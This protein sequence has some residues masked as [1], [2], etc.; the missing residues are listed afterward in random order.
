MPQRH[1]YGL[2]RLFVRHPNAANL[3][4]AVMLLAGVFSLWRM[5]TQFFPTVEIPAISISISW[6]GAS[7]EDVE[8]NIVEALEP[9][10]RF[11]SGLD[12]LLAFAREGAATFNMEF[13]SDTD[14]QGA[15]SDVEAAVDGVTTL[16]DES[17][18]P[19]ITQ[20]Q[21]YE[22]VASIALSGPFPEAT[23]KRYAK[24]LRD[25]LLEAGIDRVVF[26]GFRDEEI[27]VQVRPRDLR[28]LDLTVED[29]AARISNV[30]R[31]IPSGILEGSVDRQ[32]R[33][34]GLTETAETVA[35]IEV[36]GLPGG[37]KIV[38]RDIAL[39]EERFERDAPIGY[40]KENRAIKL[41]VQRAASA[42][43]LK[44]AEILDDYLDK[45]LPTLPPTLKVTKFDV[46]A[47]L[48]SQRINLLVKNGLG[49]L[50]LVL[51]V[52]F[53]FLNA[54]IAFWVAVGIPVAMMATM[55]VMF[56]SGQSINMVSL[57]ALILTLGIIV[58][59]AIVVGEHT[60]TLRERGIEPSEAAE[61][62]A[63]RM[64]MPVMAATLTT[65]AAFMPIFM[66][67]KVIG[68]IMEALPLV[69][70]AVLVASVIECFLILPG[71]LQHALMRGSKSEPGRFRT[72]F[73][74]GFARFRDGPFRS[75]AKS[76]FE[77]RYTT[78]AVTIGALII[79][80]GLIVGGRIGF[81]FFPAPEPE[82]IEANV[83]FAAGTP[84]AEADAALARIAR[85]LDAA[86]A[87]LTD[88]KGGLVVTSYTT[89]GRAGE[90]VG[91]SLAVIEAELKPAEERTIRTN[92]VIKA[93]TAAVPDIPGVEQLS[94]AGRRGGPPGRDVHVE[95]R[96]KKPV[97]LKQAALEVRDAL[98]Q[99][100]GVSA[101]SDDLAYGKQ[102][103]ILELTPRGSTLGFTTESVGAQVRNAFEGRIAKRFAR[104]DEEITLRVK[105][106]HSSDGIQ[107]LRELYLRSPGGEE[108]PLTEVISVREK[109]G[110]SVIQRR[111]GKPVVGI[112]GEVDQAVTDNQAIVDAMQAGPVPRIAAK[113]GLDYTFRGRAE[114][115]AETFADLKVGG[116][117]ALLIIYII[118]AWVFGSYGKPLII[119]AIIPFGLVGAI[120]GHLVMGFPLT[121]LSFFGLLGLS[122][123]LVNDSII[124]VNQVQRRI[125][126][127]ESLHD[128]AIGGAQDRLRAVLLTSLTTIGGLT[129]LMFE[130]SLQAQFLLP[131]AITLVFGLAVAT[132][133]VLVL[134]PALLGIADDL[135]RR[136]HELYRLVRP[137]AA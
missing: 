119:M 5:N 106:R 112:Y 99:L 7:A 102:E 36:K 95:L 86:E 82:M 104:G 137:K 32:L 126:E 114:E 92:T 84:L 97:I 27:W 35:G 34:I 18:R 11:I 22:D 132:L 85:A 6:P 116:M 47:N 79:S 59:D 127:G 111:D 121:I 78:V 48:V 133:L 46:R 65:Q 105:E 73:D 25:G 45:V 76:G 39:I 2:I 20:F 19:V 71:H 118:L 129:P 49:G 56:L 87:K 31:D 66:V 101:I 70:I 38:L 40:Q 125:S 15:L 96:G 10:L 136:I 42:D 62:G 120:F 14:M 9:E 51:I 83:V 107:A 98:S 30:S 74:R 29:I 61:R 1:T 55:A 12:K 109:A 135:S 75:L 13:E 43:T 89:R 77:W 103:L 33:A 16:P 90:S 24:L 124:L 67:R 123:I 110:F 108:V 117:L 69:V 88:G 17:E 54:R 93:W 52:L 131:M 115:S 41:R 68:D 72:A 50:V 21:F 128:A 8:Q 64:L 122:G 80:V 26:R 130:K 4:M 3:L 63:M 113:Y 81:K 53:V 100:P 58:D 94:I 44:V 28:R 91:D 134:V 60:A 57:F 23:L 37:E